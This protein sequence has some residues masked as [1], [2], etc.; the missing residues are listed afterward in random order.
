[1]YRPQTFISALISHPNHLSSALEDGPYLC[2][3]LKNSDIVTTIN[4]L[5]LALNDAIDCN[6][7]HALH[8]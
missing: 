1:M 3:F 6:N 7:T 2:S 4:T 8:L 5:G